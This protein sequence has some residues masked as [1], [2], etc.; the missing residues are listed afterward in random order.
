MLSGGT[1]FRSSG[2]ATTLG[3]NGVDANSATS[4]NILF[5]RALSVKLYVIAIISGMCTIFHM[6]P[7]A[8]AASFLIPRRLSR[9]SQPRTDDA[10]HKGCCFSLQN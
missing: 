4:L 5:N 8:L 7:W 3:D 2:F 1:H 10:H 9:A 6:G